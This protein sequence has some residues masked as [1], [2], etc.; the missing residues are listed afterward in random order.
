MRPTISEL[1]SGA[2]DILGD[3]VLPSVD[4][5]FVASQIT[6]VVTLLHGLASDWENVVASLVQDNAALE[7]L[8]LTVGPALADS[9]LPPDRTLAG[10]LAAA[11][12]D[13]LGSE[14]RFAPL[15]ERHRRLRRLLT[16]LIVT[17]H[18]A[19]EP[20]PAYTEIRAAVLSY[21]KRAIQPL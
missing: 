4:D 11:A 20:P 21:L 2:A 12:N 13:R 14:L 6:S 16:E 3:Q 17:I 7:A 10:D 19:D 18:R 5:L 8:F 9:P 1:L 15:D